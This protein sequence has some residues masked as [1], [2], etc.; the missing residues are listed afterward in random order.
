MSRILIVTE[1]N[2]PTGSAYSLRIH[3][4][5]RIFRALQME[6]AVVCQNQT[7]DSEDGV[8]IYPVGVHNSKIQKL[9]LPFDMVLKTKA[10]I[11]SFKPDFILS[12]SIYDCFAGILKLARSNN[13]PI[14]LESCECYDPSTFHGGK[15]SPHYILFRYCWK[16]VF[17]HVDGVIAISC[18]LQKHYLQ[19]VSDAVR[20]P[21]ILD[22][23][24]VEY[25]IECT[26]DQTLSLLF[27]GT[28]ARTKDSVKPYFEAMEKMG[29]ER[30][31]IRFTICGESADAL[32]DH[33]GE[34]LYQKY[35]GQ[36]Q[37]LGKVPQEQ[38]NRLY[39]E[40]DFGIFFRPQQTSSYA[41]FST[42]LGEGMSAGTPFLINI[43][44]DIPLYIQDKYNGLLVK[45]DTVDEVKETLEYALKMSKEE[46]SRMRLNARNTAE[47]DF[48]ALTYTED[49]HKMLESIQRRKNGE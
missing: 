39:R 47:Q 34:A 1:S 36:I 44:G 14:I 26:S 27:A 17:C 25:E 41:G 12:S 4:I 48:N 43:T 23:A 11:K 40:H 37:C 45:K 16:H 33:I 7:E 2:F 24:S 28:F 9:K 46:K 49:I 10:V 18:F 35:Q 38:I 3:S 22:T 32:K 5:S 6:V 15:G 8:K 42:K 20:I 13:I 19:Y 30:N 21:T 29:T 31:R